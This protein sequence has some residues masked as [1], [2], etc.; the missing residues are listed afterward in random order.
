MSSGLTSDLSCALS[1]VEQVEAFL[2]LKEGN[3]FVYIGNCENIRISIYSTTI[4]K[5]F[6]EWSSDAMRLGPLQSFRCTSNMWKTDLYPVIMPYL[7]IHIVNES[8]HPCEEL[9]IHTWC[10]GC[11]NMINKHPKTVEPEVSKPNFFKRKA[12]P[13]VS[14]HTELKDHRLPGFISQAGILIGGDK[15]KVFVLPKGNPGEFLMMGEKGPVWSL[16]YPPVRLSKD[17][18]EKMEA[19]TWMS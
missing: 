9:S 2:P 16:P 3:P 18:K 14:G 5:V 12:E 11:D 15:G 8:G 6:L 17:S 1:L 19:Q 13:K 10:P 4:L 7:R